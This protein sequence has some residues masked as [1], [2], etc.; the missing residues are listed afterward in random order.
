MKIK[1]IS[2]LTLGLTLMFAAAFVVNSRA[3]SAATGSADAVVN[4]VAACGFDDATATTTIPT[5]SGVVSNSETITRDPIEIICNGLN[6]WNI[7]ALGYSPDSSNP[8]GADG[9]TSMYSPVSGGTGNFIP[10]GTSGTNSYWSFKITSVTA[11]AGTASIATGYNAYSNIPSSA[12]TVAS[13]TG[14]GTGSSITGYLRPDYQI[15]VDG[16]QAPGTYTG[17]VK[18]TIVVNP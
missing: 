8:T 3:V 7:Q 5:A 9:N 10:T 2:I 12:V 15:F 4:V 18:Y 14:D 16:G 11:S 17:K 6:G 13:F 1:S